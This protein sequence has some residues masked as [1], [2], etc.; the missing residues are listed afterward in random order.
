MLFYPTTYL[1]R[2]YWSNTFFS[3]PNPVTIIP[4]VRKE[5]V[6]IISVFLMKGKS[7]PNG[8]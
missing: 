7:K 6:E 2:I 4:D 5:K 3:G 8:K 1:R